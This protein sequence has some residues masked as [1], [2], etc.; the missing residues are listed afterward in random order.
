MARRTRHKSKKRKTLLY[1]LIKVFVLAVIL[2]AIVFLAHRYYFKISPGAGARIPKG[3]YCIG[4][5][6]SKYQ[7]DIQWKDLKVLIDER[8]ITTDSPDKAKEERKVSFVFIKATEGASHTDKK[9]KHHWKNAGK[10]G[11]RRGAYHFF[12]SSKDPERQAKHFIKTVGKLSENDL[13]P[14][15]DIETIHD[16]CTEKTLNQNALIWLKAVEE[17]YGRKPIVYSSASFINNILCEEIK[18]NYHIWVAHYETML[19]RCKE[20]HIWQFSD[21]ANI[22][23]IDGGVDINVTTPDFLK[24]I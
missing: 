24:S 9:F 21:Q 6:V 20:W 15:L 13:P 10:V 2:A 11:I 3:D 8:G 7:P 19:P 18:E 17:H 22:Y 16:G 5:D 23:G 4:I 12:R 14:V 1:S